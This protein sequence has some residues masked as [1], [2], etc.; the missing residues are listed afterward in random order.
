MSAVIALSVRLAVHRSG[1]WIPGTERRAGSSGIARSFY[2][3]EYG[4]KLVQ[5]VPCI[6]FPYAGALLSSLARNMLPLSKVHSNARALRDITNRLHDTLTLAEAD[7][8]HK[9]ES[10]ND[11]LQ[12]VHLAGDHV[13]SQSAETGVD[14]PPGTRTTETSYPAL[15]HEGSHRTEHLLS[16]I[17]MAHPPSG[18]SFVPHTCLGTNNFVIILQ[19]VHSGGCQFFM[20]PIS[21]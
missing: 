16:R 21:H 11:G 12:L 1:M 18:I 14:P 5:T 20:R 2:L 4:L 7:H 19:P 15:N 13:S 8:D 3:Y 6:I 9:E 17:S 10:T